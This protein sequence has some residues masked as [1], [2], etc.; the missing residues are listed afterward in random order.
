MLDT[1]R[2]ILR[3]PFTSPFTSKTKQDCHTG[4]GDPDADDSLTGQGR[5][6]G[7]CPAEH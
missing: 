2:G 5:A 7:K 6:A 3:A 4:D 1:A